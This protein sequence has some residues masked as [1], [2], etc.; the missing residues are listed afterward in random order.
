MKPIYMI[1]IYIALYYLCFWCCSEF[2]IFWNAY[3]VNPNQNICPGKKSWD[4]ISVKPLEISGV[5]KY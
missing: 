2:Q 5:Q 3:K 1:V 4:E